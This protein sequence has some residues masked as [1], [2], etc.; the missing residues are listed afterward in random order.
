MKMA[1]ILGV[2]VALALGAPA[3]A[4]SVTFDRGEVEAGGFVWTYAPL[5]EV[6]IT[7]N[8]DLQTLSYSRVQ[9]GLSALDGM[10]ASYGSEASGAYVSATGHAEA[11][12]QLTTPWQGEMK[13]Y[14][15]AS[16]NVGPSPSTA[17]WMGGA[18]DGAQ[19]YYYFTVNGTVTFTA[20]YSSTATFTSSSYPVSAEYYAFLALG[21]P[22]GYVFAYNMSSNPY[23]GFVNVGA[24]GNVTVQLS[25]GN[26]WLMGTTEEGD[27]ALAVGPNEAVWGS[28]QELV[29]FA[30]SGA[31]P[32]SAVP[33][34]P[35][36]LM[37]LLGF[38]GL[39]FGGY[40]ASRRSIVGA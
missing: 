33:E 28:S 20:S 18:I 4:S 29:N 37:L 34:A 6:P 12:F 40:R 11:I 7:Y 19:Q 5:T 9:T 30:M 1:S 32:V 22:N 23:P 36:W 16:A 39:G 14:G 2:A 25:S 31:G 13:G 26:Y 10:T 3:H 8:Q 35:T 38:A 27:A 17:G 21:G 15:S 24:S